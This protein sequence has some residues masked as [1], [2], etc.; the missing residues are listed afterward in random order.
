[1]QIEYHCTLKEVAEQL[2]VSTAQARSIERSALEKFKQAL[3][4]KGFDEEEIAE[5]ME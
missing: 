5:L 1:M 4:A 3:I 2:G